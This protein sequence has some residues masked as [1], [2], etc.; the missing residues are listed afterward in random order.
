MGNE[1]I[2]L[3]YFDR[4]KE[5]GSI[6]LPTA[7]FMNIVPSFPPDGRF[8]LFRTMLEKG[9]CVPG[10]SDSGGTEPEAPNPL[11]QIW[12]MAERKSQDGEV[13]N[14]EECISVSEGLETYTMHS[15]FAN[16]EEKTKGSIESG[17][18]ADLVI[19]SKD[20][21]ASVADEIRNI[22]VEMTIVGGKIVYERSS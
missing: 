3:K 9:L 16:L 4:V 21:L 12:C 1:L 6:A 11:Y 10:N 5:S 8:F 19:F 7:Y 22:P 2:D 13:V 15:A 17:K 20:P 18:L 14:A